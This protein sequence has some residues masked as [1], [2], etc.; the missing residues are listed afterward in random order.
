MR[1]NPTRPG[2]RVPRQF[3]TA[4][5]GERPRPLEGRSGRLELAKAIVD[6]DNPL[7]A[8][9]MVNRVWMHHFGEGLVRTP[10][11]FGLR[12]QGPT[13]P[14]LLD[15][16]ATQ[17]V[18]DGWSLKKLHRRIMLSRTYQQSSRDRA[19]CQARDPENRLLWRMN[20]RRLDFE[21]FRDTLL[22]VAG[23]ID[24]TMGGPSVELTATGMHRRTVY[25]LIDRQALSAVFPTFD[26][27]SPDA[28]SPQRYTT[29]VPQQAL[30]LLNGPWT[31]EM[32]RSLVARDD[33]QVDRGPTGAS[34]K[35]WNCPGG[36]VHVRAKSQ[37]AWE[38]LERDKAVAQAGEALDSWQALRKRCCCP[39]S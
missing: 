37:L 39:T 32:S 7:T 35:W 10:S 1:G 21:A 18:N 38:F 16:L 8:R 25:G 5:A 33:V 12:G 23:R 34:A 15:Y 6:R 3:L 19:E 36:D 2:R 27:A 30:F 9:V 13:H 17:F 29:T 24:L 22:T 20:R 11:N 26:F 14:D 28:H 31:L 4:L